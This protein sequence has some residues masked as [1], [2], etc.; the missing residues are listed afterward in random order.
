MLGWNH[1]GVVL[2]SYTSYIWAS[3]VKRP[4]PCFPKWQ[5]C[6]RE[7]GAVLVTEI[8][9]DY[10]V[11][12]EPTPQE[13]SCPHLPTS[14]HLLLGLFGNESTVLL[15]WDDWAILDIVVFTQYGG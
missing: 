8:I 7:E 9:P 5:D 6:P 14:S 13:L 11:L 15:F 12:P 3:A 1:L 2:Y 4:A 10:Q